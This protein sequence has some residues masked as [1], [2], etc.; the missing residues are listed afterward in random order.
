[1]SRKIEAL[2]TILTFKNPKVI[3]VSTSGGWLHRSSFPEKYLER[4]IKEIESIKRRK[5]QVG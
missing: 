5:D 4:V 1:M 3:R 2:E